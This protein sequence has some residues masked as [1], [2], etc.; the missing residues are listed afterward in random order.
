MDKD[1]SIAKGKTRFK[2]KPK[3]KT[4]NSSYREPDYLLQKIFKECFVLPS[5][6]LGIIDLENLSVAG[7]GTKIKTFASSYA[8]E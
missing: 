2:R 1:K 3:K 5:A 6:K 4:K 8:M 7:D